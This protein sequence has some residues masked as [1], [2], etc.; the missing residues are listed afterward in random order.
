[1]EALLVFLVIVMVVVA[2]VVGRVTAP[3][4]QPPAPRLGFDSF[5]TLAQR[6][7]SVTPDHA[8]SA[9]VTTVLLGG[10][11][12]VLQ[13]ARQLVAQVDASRKAKEQE[14]KDALRRA[15]VAQATAR[16]LAFR[17]GQIDALASVFAEAQGAAS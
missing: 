6:I 14:A 16:Q 1:M 15:E 8:R 5:E 13:D 17:R 9:L 10:E 12:A 11:V 3:K 7:G 4:S 2:W